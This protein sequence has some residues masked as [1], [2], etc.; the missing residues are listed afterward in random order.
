MNAES[1]RRELIVTV[2]CQVI[3]LA[4]RQYAIDF[5]ALDARS[6]HELQ[7]L[8]RDMEVEKVQAV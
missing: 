4:G 2:R 7:R 5:M 8:L 6:L 3:R 1:E